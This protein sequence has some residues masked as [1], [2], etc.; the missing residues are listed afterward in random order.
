MA[1]QVYDSYGRPIT[2][3]SVVGVM[4]T[5]NV[6]DYGATGDGSTNDAAAIQLAIKAAGAMGV[7]GRGV[8]VYFPAGVYAI[9][10]TLAVPFN[11]VMLKGSGWQSTVIYAT[12]T[13]SDI[14]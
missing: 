1:W 12:F 11:N 7:S 4:T 5:V 6:K 3:S 13:T 9:G 10:S 2:T 8:D 14:I